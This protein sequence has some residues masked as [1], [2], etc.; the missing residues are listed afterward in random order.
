VPWMSQ[1]DMLTKTSTVYNT[2]NK[3]FLGFD[4]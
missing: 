4:G 1:Y 3:P 2:D